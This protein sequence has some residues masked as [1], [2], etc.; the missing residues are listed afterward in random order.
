MWVGVSALFGGL[1]SNL[2]TLGVLTPLC[3]KQ[4]ASKKGVTLALIFTT[5]LTIDSI[6]FCKCLE[7]Y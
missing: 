1:M 2:C 7:L 3:Q 5:F 6:Y 4:E